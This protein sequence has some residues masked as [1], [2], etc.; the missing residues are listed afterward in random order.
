MDV[1]IVNAWLIYRRQC[2]ARN[3]IN[4]KKLVFQSEIGQSVIQGYT[5]TRKKGTPSSSREG[6]P[7]SREGT[8]NCFKRKTSRGTVTI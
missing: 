4:F 6:T 3:I 7:T 5:S 8:V 1:S 2:A